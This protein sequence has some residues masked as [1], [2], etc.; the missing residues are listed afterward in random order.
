MID[1]VTPQRMRV[2]YALSSPELDPD[3]ALL[4]RMLSALDRLDV[5]PL[6]VCP[7]RGAFTVELDRIGI[8]YELLDLECFGGRRPYRFAANVW[9]L[10][11]LIR[12][13]H[14]DIVHTHS[15]GIAEHCFVAARMAG[16]RVICYVHNAASLDDV[17]AML[18]HT[19]SRCDQILAGSDKARDSLVSSLD[20]NGGNV[21]VIGNSTGRG[22]EQIRE[23]Y[24]KV[25]AQ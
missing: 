18:Q 4:L 16:S 23:I 20:I 14:I 7:D 1:N 8:P 22:I 10:A 3:Q 11:W 17:G 2:L 15:I 9:H 5:S 25:T 13:R 12:S 24:R 21:A 6:V 19:F